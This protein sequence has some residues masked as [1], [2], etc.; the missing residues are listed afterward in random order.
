MIKPIKSS[1]SMRGQS[2]NGPF[3][4]KNAKMTKRRRKDTVHIACFLVISM[5]ETKAAVACG[6]KLK[7]PKGPW[8]DKKAFVMP[9]NVID[10]TP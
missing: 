10:K 5:P 4:G 3:K 7:G 8:S 9:P 6:R 1:H 2:Q